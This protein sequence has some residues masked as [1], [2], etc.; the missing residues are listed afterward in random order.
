MFLEPGADPSAAVAGEVVRSPYDDPAGLARLADACDVATFEFENVP[1]ASAAFLQSRLPVLPPPAALEA[2]QDRLAEKHLF[3][4]VAI[5]TA[6]FHPVNAPG[7]LE[8]AL[9]VTG[10]PVV[11]KTR[12]MGYDGKGQAMAETAQDAAAAVAK[13]GPA[14]L[15]AE[16]FVHFRREL[17][18]VAAAGRDGSRI[19]YP[20]TENHHRD[21]ILRVSYAPAPD[22]APGLQADAEALIGRLLDRLEYVGV[23]AVELFQTDDGFLANEM[24][25][26]VHNSGHWTLDGA[27]ASQFENHVRAVASL[28]LADPQPMAAA[29]AMIN[30]ISE[31]PP[32]ETLAAIPG[33]RLHLYGKSPRPG[34]KLGHVNVA[35]SDR[36]TVMATARRAWGLTAAEGRLPGEG[37]LVE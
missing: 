11:I 3:R 31:V 32:T 2:S 9:E 12:R 17:S 18:I 4:Q 10:L 23:L 26:R 27:A 30:L 28:P 16:G 5:R 37:G 21:G 8:A 29:S 19:F 15:I 20:L 33:L 1:A 7:D 13:L 25:P 14:N 35:G 24:A 22:L 36:A 34:R 6:P